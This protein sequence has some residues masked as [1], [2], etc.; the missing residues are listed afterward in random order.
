V[1]IPAHDLRLACLASY[2]ADAD[3]S[4]S[5]NGAG[6][7]IKSEPLPII[8]K[9]SSNGQSGGNAS[10]SNHGAGKCADS[11]GDGRSAS[12]GHG[13]ELTADNSTGSGADE[14]TAEDGNT[15]TASRQIKLNSV[16]K[17]DTNLN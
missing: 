2:V 9:C 7:L 4:A 13:H 6:G 3:E 14:I 16:K 1:P 5:G 12:R 10:G 8:D 11:T 17:I 15:T